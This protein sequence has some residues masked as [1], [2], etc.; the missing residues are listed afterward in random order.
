MAAALQAMGLPKGARVAI[1]S[2]NCAHWIM[3]DLA[4]LMAGFVSVPLY[5]TLSAHGIRQIL[6]HSGSEVIFLGKLDDYAQQKEG[7]PATIKKISFPW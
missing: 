2:K 6:E 4:I 5:A 7:I 1:L 3:A